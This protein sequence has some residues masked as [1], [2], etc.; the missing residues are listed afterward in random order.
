MSNVRSSILFSF[1]GKYG[2]KLIN[3]VSTIF[4]A[5]LL[6]PTEIGTF[7]I[8]SSVVMILAEIRLLGAAAYLVREESIDELKIR[9][10]YGITYLMCWGLASILI[11]GSGFI[12]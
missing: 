12:G 7:A 11:V 3:L 6:T 1:A 4:I 9:R 10:A 8:A 5:R 2:S